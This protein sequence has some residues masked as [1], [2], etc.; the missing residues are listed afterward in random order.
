MEVDVLIY[1]NTLKN[2]FDKDQQ[3]YEDMFGTLTI[4]KDI[5]FKKII[6]IANKNYKEN[7]EAILSTEQI[8]EVVD[9]LLGKKLSQKEEETKL[10]P[11]FKKILKDFPPFSL[12]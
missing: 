3:A 2:F 5:F 9:E 4:N 7:G 11:S 1:I 10:H 6:K 8:Y 12:N